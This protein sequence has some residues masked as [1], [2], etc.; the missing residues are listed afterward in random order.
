MIGNKAYRMEN[1]KCGMLKRGC[2]IPQYSLH[3]FRSRR[4][5]TLAETMVALSLF[6][7]VVTISAQIFLSFQRISRKTEGLEKLTTSARM[8]VESMAQEIRSG[9][10]NYAVYSSGELPSTA[11]L[12]LLSSSQALVN[13]VLSSENMPCE[14]GTVGACVLM[15]REGVS[16]L[17]G[18]LEQLTGQDIN[19]RQL[20]F[21]IFPTTNPF[22]NY[23]ANNGTYPSNQQPRVTILLS[24]DN[25]RAIGAA[26]YARYDVQTTISSRT[27]PR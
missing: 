17:P 19:V 13:F 14:S 27:Y 5:F 7:V 10:I 26:D 1:V 9:T 22:A 25:G 8:I 15:E 24:L 11:G 6:A 2:K 23:N 3:I 4:G 12:H 16:A 21:F 20:Q 18:S